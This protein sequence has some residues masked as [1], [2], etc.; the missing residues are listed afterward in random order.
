[1]PCFRGIELSVVAT[2]DNSDFP[3]FPH[4]DGSSARFDRLKANRHSGSM[5]LS[6]RPREQGDERLSYT[7]QQYA[8]PRISVYI[9]SAAETNF[10]FRYNVAQ[11]PAG[12]R[13][14]CFRVLINGRDIVSWG[15]DLDEAVAGATYQALFQPSGKYERY[16]DGVLMTQYGIESRCFRFVTY[17]AEKASVADDGGLIEVQ[18]FRAKARSR[19]APQPDHYRGREK[20]GIALVSNGLLEDPQAAS[21]Y[22]Y[23]LVDAKD[24]PYA[25]FRFHY[26]SWENLRSLQLAP[27]EKPEFLCSSPSRTALARRPRKQ[28][29]CPTPNTDFA[30]SKSI[31]NDTEQKSYLRR[32]RL[33]QDNE[34][35]D[36]D[37]YINQNYNLSGACAQTEEEAHSEGTGYDTAPRLHTKGTRNER[38]LPQLPTVGKST[39]DVGL[40]PD[41]GTNETAE[42]LEYTTFDEAGKLSIH[43]TRA[44]SA[45]TQGSI[46]S[47]LPTAG[48]QLT[49]TD[50]EDDLSVE[51]MQ[52]GSAVEVGIA[53]YGKP[54]GKPE[55]PQSECMSP[56]TYTT[57]P[58]Q[59]RRLVS[60]LGTGY[61]LKHIAPFTDDLCKREATKP[62]HR[63]LSSDSTPRSW[64]SP[65]SRRPHGGSL[66]SSSQLVLQAAQTMSETKTK[67]SHEER[68]AHEPRDM[69]LPGQW[70][71]CI[72]PGIAKAGGFTITSTPSRAVTNSEAN[73]EDRYIELAVKASPENPAAAWLWQD[74]VSSILGHTL[75]VRIGGSFVF[76]PP[77]LDLSASF[78]DK[79]P[80]RIVFVAGGVGINPLIS[81]VCHIGEMN[82]ASADTDE[83]GNAGPEVVFLYTAREESAATKD[84]AEDPAS[85]IL[86]MQRLASLYSRK[87]IR[88]QLKV[89]LTGGESST[90]AEDGALLCNEESVPYERRRITTADVDAAVLDG[91]GR[92]G[93][94][95]VQQEQWRSSPFIAPSLV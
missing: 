70:V 90:A 62:R 2:S 47:N 85:R 84:E 75:Q 73:P 17:G 50:G 55:E 77:G 59:E 42:W 43:R 15:I 54:S 28:F 29:Q 40:F 14:L 38:P 51:T 25:S 20:Y 83:D 26:R 9:P 31:A 5:F 78:Q 23:H 1:M 87:S 10:F 46:T 39:V 74:P 8:D 81:M 49:Y 44:S 57:Q 71:D 61:S 95:Y 13:Y 3:E 41:D 21:Y 64:G 37:N 63:M 53:Y 45:M 79:K 56:E 19:R 11:P 35:F 65:V 48:S 89:F 72:V 60:R 68:T 12:Q 67:E 32:D 4:P 76:P 92:A 22:D 58:D 30:A 69:F 24:S 88:G 52:Y 91:P 16:V 34:T 93:N 94:V 80:A 6:P 33:R 66:D 18:V 36:F 82:D 86:F 7:T 27:A